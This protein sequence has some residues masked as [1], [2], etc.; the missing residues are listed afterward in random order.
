MITATAQCITTEMLSNTLYCCRN[1][2]ELLHVTTILLQHPHYYHI[3]MYYYI[4][5]L[6]H[7][8]LWKYYMFTADYYALLHNC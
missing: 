1:I 4:F 7:Y 2:V 6:K 8:V 5:A 3:I